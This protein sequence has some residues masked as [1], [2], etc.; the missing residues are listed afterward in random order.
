M[1]WE[2]QLKAGVSTAFYCYRKTFAIVT[3][4]DRKTDKMLPFSFRKYCEK[5]KENDLLCQQLVLA[6]CFS[7]VIK[8]RLL[9]RGFLQRVF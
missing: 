3:K 4:L 8:V 6:L 5:R 9:A 7:R 1:L 2:H